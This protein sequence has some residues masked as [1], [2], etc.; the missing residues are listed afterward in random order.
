MPDT[1]FQVSGYYPLTV[2]SMQRA[3]RPWA[4]WKHQ[5]WDLNPCESNSKGR[6]KERLPGCAYFCSS[7]AFR[8]S[9]AWVLAPLSH[10]VLGSSSWSMC[11]CLQ[12]SWGYLSLVEGIVKS[13]VLEAQSCGDLSRHCGGGRAL[14]WVHSHRKGKSWGHLLT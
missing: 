5:S 12:C 1:L 9:P 6:V 13:V 8:P 11:R 3:R 4:R 2:L 14:N 10:S 7:C